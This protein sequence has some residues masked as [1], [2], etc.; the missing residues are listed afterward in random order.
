MKEISAEQQIKEIQDLAILNSL[1]GE[2][3][4]NVMEYSNDTN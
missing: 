2:V 1:S 3:V 4:I